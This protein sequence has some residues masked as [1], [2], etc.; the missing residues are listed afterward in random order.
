MQGRKD[1]ESKLFYTVTLSRLVPGDHPVRRICEVLDLS[2]LYKETREY[3]SHEGKPSIDP[4]V[5]FKLYILGYFFGISS[6]RRLF[7]EVQVNLAYRW[8]LGYDLDEEIPDHSVM[9]KSRYRFPVEVF[10]RLFKRI[11]HLCKEKGLISGDYHFVDS[12][13]VQ[14]DASRESF[15]P[16]LKV[17]QEYLDG[18]SRPEGPK[19]AAQSRA[20]DGNLDPENMGKRRRRDR[21]NDRL[22]SPTDPEAELITRPGKGSVPSYKAHFCVDRKRR[23]ILAVD[24][25]KAT[26]DDMSKVHSLF[27]NSLFAVGKKPMVVVA[28]SAY[29]GI[30]ALKYYQDQNVQTC[31]NPRISDN[32][33]GRFRNTDFT[34]IQEGEEMQCPA[35]HRVKRQTNNLYRIQFHWRKGLCNACELQTQC[36]QSPYGRIVSFYKGPYFDRARALAGSEKGKKLLRA[37]QIIAEGVIGEAKNLHLLKRCRYR[38]LDRFRVQVFLTAT[39]VNL[40][41]LLKE[42]RKRIGTAANAASATLGVLLPPAQVLLGQPCLV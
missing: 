27:T 13:I 26:D 23:V 3:Y 33:E 39:A 28:D 31:I 9:T 14:A 18:L 42:T 19:P 10:E 12:S 24:G 25:S 41:R 34:V 37:R 5:L 4:V 11:I 6:E 22:K 35:G 38:S 7:R 8:Y 20:F 1:N 36:T 29:G 15:R 17:E 21:K 16:K 40:K 30:E 32:S 2:F